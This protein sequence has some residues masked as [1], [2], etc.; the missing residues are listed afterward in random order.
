MNERKVKLMAGALLHDFGKLLYRYNDR[1]KHSVS[2]SSYISKII[3]DN[4]IIDCIKY[5]HSD[6]LKEVSDALTPNNLAYIAYIADNISSFSDRRPKFTY[7]DGFVPK[8]PLSSVFN[9]INGNNQEYGYSPQMFDEGINYP[10]SEERPFD[11][12]FYEK[13]VDKMDSYL[14]NIEYTPEYINSLL[15]AMEENLSFIPSSTKQKE[16]CDVSLYDHSKTT[17]CFAL[18]IYDYLEERNETDYKKKLFKKATEFYKEDAFVICSL[19]ISGIENF[20]CNVPSEGA[21]KT[22]RTRSFYIDM[23]LEYTID[24]MLD[25]MELFRCNLLYSGCGHA[26]MILPNTEK[27]K[28][29]IRNCVQEMNKWLMSNFGTSLFIAYGCH[30]C[31][32]NDFK[33]TPIGKNYYLFT[34]AGEA[35][36]RGK[37]H[38][39]TAAD[40]ISLN[41]PSK[42]RDNTRECKFCHNSD[43]DLQNGLCRHCLNFKNF[44][45]D[46]IEKDFFAIV[47]EHK[48][49][50]VCLALPFSKYLIGCDTYEGLCQIAE[51]ERY[52]C[53]YCKNA[54]YV[55]DRISTRLWVGDYVAEKE[56]KLLA[57]RSVGIQRIGALRA[58]IDNFA[59]AF[60]KGFDEQTATISRTSTFSRKMALFFRYHIKDILENAEFH[61]CDEE[62]KE[63]NAT[64]I[65][66][67]GDEIFI[68][69]AWNE[70]IGFMVDLQKSLKRFT[71]NTMTIS[72]GFGMYAC[73]FPISVMARETKNLERHS[74]QQIFKNSV[75]LFNEEYRY[76]WE[77]FEKGILGEKFKLIKSFFEINKDKY[78]MSL[79]YRMLDLIRENDNTKLNVA[80]FTY[81]LARLKPEGVVS[82]KNEKI[83]D[84]LCEK[85]YHWLTSDK[86]RRQLI[87]AIYL[88]V[89][90]KRETSGGNLLN[91]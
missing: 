45:N 86:D 89:Y 56:L 68:V 72:A 12:D 70:I 57:E 37:R 77:E 23:V 40:I 51:E 30:I 52:V 13:I 65:Y 38:R 8:V 1:R 58:N 4:E 62:P 49:D 24:K 31:N 14:R 33:N 78:G 25:E 3:D 87:T 18:C 17:A 73:N 88:Y 11:K 7:K 54:L 6:A 36:E 47:S 35:T 63:R 75:T 81:L 79:I 50:E 2:G 27:V 55:G 71:Q 43:A 32:S 42:N 90:T 91:E 60:A 9:I 76:S 5:H 66:S 59:E 16:Y 28:N 34:K 64:I 48:D 83:Y 69:G 39:Y 15:G 82:P 20:I 26:Y 29:I 46:I 10:E 22:T 67:G 44:S 61:L 85:M 74:K 21:L 41:A 53:S 84:E 19:D 80:R